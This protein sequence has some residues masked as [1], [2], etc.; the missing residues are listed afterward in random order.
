MT[1][2]EYPWLLPSAMA[3]SL[4]PDLPGDRAKAGRPRR[5]VRDWVV[6]TLAFLIAALIGLLTSEAS[7]QAGNSEL[8]VFADQLVGAAACCAL[9]ARRRVPSGSRSA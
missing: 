8:V 9:W 5:T 7:A 1:R 3:E 4:D 2:T 6:D